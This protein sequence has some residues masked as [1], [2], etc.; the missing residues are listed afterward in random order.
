MMGPTG[1]QGDKGGQGM[2]GHTGPQGDKGDQ[3]IQG[4]TGSQGNKGDKGDKGP[5]GPQG[6]QGTTGPQGP[7]GECI[8]LRVSE[9]NTAM[10]LINNVFY[11][12]EIGAKNSAGQGYRVLKIL[13]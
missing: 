1:I 8:G 10:L 2:M 4:P 12:V 3:G 11:K 7:V 9:D 5:T 13:N 6:D